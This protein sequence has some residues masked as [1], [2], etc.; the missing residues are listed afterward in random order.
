MGTQDVTCA[1]TTLLPVQTLAG[2]AGNGVRTQL[3]QGKKTGIFY[4]SDASAPPAAH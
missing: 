1:A 2:G 3:G 4:V